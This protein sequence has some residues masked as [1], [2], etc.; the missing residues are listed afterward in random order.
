MISLIPLLT[1]PSEKVTTVDVKEVSFLNQQL[2]ICAELVRNGEYDLAYDFDKDGYV[3]AND[4][5]ILYNM[6][7]LKYDSFAAGDPMKPGI[8]LN[9][10]IKRI[11]NGALPYDATFDLNGDGVINEFD[12]LIATDWNLFKKREKEVF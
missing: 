8:M 4:Y 9:I 5:E 12:L 2:P 3:T 6:Y 1:L 10:R 7:Y 11:I